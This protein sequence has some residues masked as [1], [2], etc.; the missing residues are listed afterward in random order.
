MTHGQASLISAFILRLSAALV[1]LAFPVA[2]AA[3]D[4]DKGLAQAE[5]WC[6]SCHSIGTDEPRQ[7]DAGPLFTELAKKDADYLRVAI[8]RPHD[9]MPEF[10]KLTDADKQD[11][12]AYIRSLK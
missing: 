3:A 10:P 12:I 9:S 6:N 1:A 2:A 4:A 11:L 5:R 7:G 8:D